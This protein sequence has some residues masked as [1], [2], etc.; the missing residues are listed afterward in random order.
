MS[1]A[2]AIITGTKASP[3]LAARAIEVAM[4]RAELTTAS[5]CSY[6]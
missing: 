6:F 2:T 1:V 3:H 4:E 5:V